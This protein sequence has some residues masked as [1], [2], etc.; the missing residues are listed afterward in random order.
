MSDLATYHLW[1]LGC[2]G[3]HHIVGP[4]LVFWGT[5]V[6]TGTPKHRQQDEGEDLIYVLDASRILLYSD[7]RVSVDD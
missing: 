1:F 7:G 2:W 4:L 3:I 6:H 5:T